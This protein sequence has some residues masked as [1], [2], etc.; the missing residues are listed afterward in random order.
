V[1]EPEVTLDRLLNHAGARLKAAGLTEP[2]REAWRIWADLHGLSTYPGSIFSDDVVPRQD[3][4]QFRQAIDRRARGEPLQYVTGVVGFRGLTLRAD[5]RAL[6]P[7]PETEGLVELVLAR[8]PS[9]RVADV[10]TGTGC[11]ALALA[12]EG[13]YDLVVAVDRSPE[14]LSLAR[15]NRRSTGLGVELVLGELVEAFGLEAFHAV[16]SNPPYL[17]DLEY[18]ALDASVKSWEPREA[19]A[20]GPDG[21]APTLAIIE[22]ALRVIRPGGWLALEVDASRAGETARLAAT[23]GWSDVTIHDDLFGRARYLLARRSE[24]L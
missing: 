15:E 3:A 6:I 19:L 17:T 8:A 9:G 13:R 5:R 20:A 16:V 1:T 12:E 14:A 18:E 4:E 10:G 22:D 7:R 21:L 11:I 2:R 23:A 24:A